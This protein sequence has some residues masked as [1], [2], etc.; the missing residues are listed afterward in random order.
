MPQFNFA[1]L[2]VAIAELVRSS[3]P[4]DIRPE[5]F[6]HCQKLILH[7]ADDSGIPLS[8]LTMLVLRDMACEML[9][10]ANPAPSLLN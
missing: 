5:M 3:S 4:D 2:L 6:E 9:D 8:P 7:C 1:E 10:K